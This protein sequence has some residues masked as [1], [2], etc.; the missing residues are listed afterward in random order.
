MVKVKITGLQNLVEL[1]KEIQKAVKKGSKETL[2][3]LALQQQ[4]AIL[5]GRTPD[6]SAQKENATKYAARK[7]AL[8]ENGKIAFN[9]PLYKTGFLSNAKNWKVSI[10]QTKAVLKPPSSRSAI[11]YIL[12][13]QGFDTVLNEL[14]SDFAKRLDTNLQRELDKI[15]KK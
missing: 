9:R 14:P 10:G 13:A 12:A 1:P 7:K 11:V 15:D 4:N 3:Y 6:G 5:T 8:K 2:N